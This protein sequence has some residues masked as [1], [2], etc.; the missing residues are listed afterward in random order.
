M[1]VKALTARQQHCLDILN[2]AGQ[3]SQSIAEAARAHGLCASTL[4]SVRRVLVAKGALSGSVPRSGA[5]FTAI[6]LSSPAPEQIELRT[7]L[8]NGQPLWLGVPAGHLPTVLKAL[9][10]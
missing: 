9:S 7:C 8:S 4:Y 5:G 10:P 2:T 1:I 3:R 6:P